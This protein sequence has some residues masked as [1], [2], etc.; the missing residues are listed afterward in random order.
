M[1]KRTGFITISEDGVAK[2]IVLRL[3]GVKL[4]K[5]ESIQ[6]PLRYKPTHYVNHYKDL[7]RIT[8]S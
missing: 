7:H 3:Q 5:V 8:K 4:N 2:E 1:I 6:I